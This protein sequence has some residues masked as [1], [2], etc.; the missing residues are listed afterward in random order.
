MILLSV[1]V[2]LLLLKNNLI[3]FYQS[4]NFDQSP[5][6]HLG[7]GTMFLGISACTFSL[8]IT[9]TIDISVSIC[10]SSLKASS[11][12]FKDPSHS[13]NALILFVLLELILSC[14]H[15]FYYT[16]FVFDR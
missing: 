10:S 13:D 11:V 14:L 1:P 8:F 4:S 12:I 2:T 5:S 7:S 16:C 9:G 6:N 3:P 15:S